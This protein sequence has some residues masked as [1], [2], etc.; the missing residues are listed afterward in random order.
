MD[1]HLWEAISTLDLGGQ[2][3]ER[4]LELVITSAVGE[5]S[6]RGTLEEELRQ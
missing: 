1:Q 5:V 3:G 6:P 4:F 2:E